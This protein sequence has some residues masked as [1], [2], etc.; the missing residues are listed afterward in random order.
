MPR[1]C[2][3][4]IV[5]TLGPASSTPAQMEALF[6]AGAD[7]FRLN[8]SHGT[9]D[10]HRARHAALRALESKVGSPVGVLVDLQGPKL[11]VG[12]FSGGKIRLEAGQRFRLDLDSAPGD[13]TRVQLPHR[14]IFAA[15]EDGTDLLL[16]DGKLRL[17]VL[18]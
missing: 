9:H 8:F 10:D 12:A 15:I 16:D 2:S 18:E 11:R 13:A 5:A 4:K 14:E 3:T 1:L 17:R 7:V 6:G